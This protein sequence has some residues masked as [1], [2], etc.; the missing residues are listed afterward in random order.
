MFGERRDLVTSLDYT[1]RTPD[2]NP[3]FLALFAYDAALADMFPGSGLFPPLPILDPCFAAEQPGRPVRA[4][5]KLEHRWTT[6][7]IGAHT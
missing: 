1:T 4:Q 6:V 7:N 3:K 2:M 5:C